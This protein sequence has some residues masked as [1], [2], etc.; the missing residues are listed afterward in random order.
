MDIGVYC[1]YPM[2]Q[3]FGRPD[4]IKASGLMLDSGVDGEGSIL[5]H[6]MEMEGTVMFSKVT[7][8]YIPSEIQGEN[9]SIL[10]DK[11]SEPEKVEIR[12]RDGRVEDISNLP[13]H[14]TMYYETKEFIELIK[15]GSL[16]STVNT[17]ENSIAVMEIL[18]EARKQI[19]LKFPADR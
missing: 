12:Y 13:E 1:I 5:A 2:V 6:Y 19:G 11:I 16:E 15:N 7:N 9:G 14:H 4:S 3:L 8:S 17:Y 10:I 18:D